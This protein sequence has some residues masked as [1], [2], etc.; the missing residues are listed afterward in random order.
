MAPG[1]GPYP[2]STTLPQGAAATGMSP[3]TLVQLLGHCEAGLSSE[4]VG[5]HTRPGAHQTPSIPC[6]LPTP[7]LA[8]G[9]PAPC[10]LL[11]PLLS[12]ARGCPSAV[13]TLCWQ[14]GNRDLE[15]STTTPQL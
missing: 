9:N 3:Q 14:P 8:A 13:T 6:S 11:L 10:L 5:M 12:T 4:A 15:L 1:H 7:R 2:T